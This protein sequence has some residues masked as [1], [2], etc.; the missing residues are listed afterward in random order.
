MSQLE[1]KNIDGFDKVFNNAQKDVEELNESLQNGKIK[2]EDYEKKVKN[3]S[4]N[5]SNTIMVVEPEDASNAKE[6]M[7]EYAS[8]LKNVE[9][10]T[11]NE[12]TQSLNVKFEDQN[13][14]VK[15]VVLKYDEMT[16]AIQRIDK[17]SNNAQGKLNSFFTG[18]KKKLF[19]LGQYL[20]TFV[21]F[22]EV[23]G[24]IKQGVSVVRELDTALTEMRKVSDETVNSLKNFQKTSFDIAGSIGTTATQIQ[25]STA[26]FMRLG[27]TLEQ[28]TESAKTA[29]IL[30]NVSE[31]ESIED[32]TESLVAMSAAY[33]DLD[34]IE[35][36]DKLNLIG[37]E[38]SISS[39]GIATAL[40][41]SASALTT[42]SNDI[43][44]AIALVTAGNQV[45]QDPSSVGSGLRTIALRLTGTKEAEQTLTDLGEDTEGVITTVS[46]LRDTIMSATAVSKNGFK[47]FDILDENGNYKSTYEILLGISK[48][49]QD[50]VETDKK[51]GSNNVNLL[52]ETI[53]GK[54]RANI[55][56]SILQNSKILED[57]YNSSVYDSAG[58]SEEELNAYLDSIEGKISKF[59]NEVQEFWY[60]LIKSDTV[61]FFVSEA[62]KIVDAIGKITGALGEWGTASSILIGA[63]N[64]RASKNGGGR[65]KMFTLIVNKYATESFSREV[66]EF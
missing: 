26:D 30:L 45:V 5:L 51:T 52:L 19:A 48:I 25:N 13:K 15:E 58:S 47:G 57:V 41:D 43:D 17:A 6:K 53:A 44:E 42:A 34:K 7:Y 33:Q 62:T 28:A 4:T 40:Q 9:L 32:A 64:M 56:A 35:I 22:Y 21:G 55:A 11:F 14:I 10:G 8:S 50:I 24:A 60:G 49:Y 66:C 20:M 39:D 29:N 27:E 23:W 38:F 31:F 2:L 1:H 46:K 16:G 54:N 36:V 12:Q 65:V 63:I 37:N 59:Q 3:I 18:L 61:K